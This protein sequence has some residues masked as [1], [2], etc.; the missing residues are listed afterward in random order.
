MATQFDKERH[1]KAFIY[2][3]VICSVLLIAFIFISWKTPPPAP[4][5]VQDLMEINLGNDDEGFG[6]EQPLIKGERSPEPETAPSPPEAKP[7]A[8]NEPVAEDNVT[9]DDNAPD[10]AAPV[11]KTVKKT[12]STKEVVTP[13]PVTKPTVKPTTPAPVV[14]P[15]PKP[16]VPK[17]VYTG[18]GKGGGNNATTDNGYTMQGN[19]KGGTGDAGSPNGN[20]DTYGNKPGG[21]TV[22]GPKVISGSRKL[23]Y[24]SYNFTGDLEKATINAVVKV[25]PEG[26]GTFVRFAAGSTTTE[27]RYA[28]AIRGYLKNMPFDK[29]DEDGVVTVQFN[30]NVH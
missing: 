13:T 26:V 21:G 22:G 16:R 10:E 17:V 25:S 20:K 4:P 30:F 19:K 27:A 23:I 15:T 12:T 18:P 7:V 11:V 3:A 9:P 5:V 1:R 28:N 14:T 2:T 8:A 24:R 29:Q 6:E